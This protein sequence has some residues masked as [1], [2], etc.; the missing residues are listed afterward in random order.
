MVGVEDY[1]QTTC[2]T[3][4]NKVFELKFKRFGALNVLFDV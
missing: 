4:G 2:L 3:R 1:D